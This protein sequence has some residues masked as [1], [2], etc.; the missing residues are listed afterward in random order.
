L[1]GPDGVVVARVTPGQKLRI[2]HV[3]RRAV[4]SSR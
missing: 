4:M 2:A 3:L 1:D